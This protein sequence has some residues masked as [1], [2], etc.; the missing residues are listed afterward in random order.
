MLRTVFLAL[1]L[2]LGGAHLLGD[3]VEV[4]SSEQTD[5]SSSDAG[6][7]FDPDGLTSGGSGSDAD[8]DAGSRFDPNG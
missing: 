1:A 2:A 4:V 6:S 3:L 7:R 5:D 8:N